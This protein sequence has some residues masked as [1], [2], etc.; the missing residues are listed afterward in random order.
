VLFYCGGG[1]CSPSDSASILSHGGFGK[2]TL[3]R[4]HQHQRLFPGAAL[5]NR[6]YQEAKNVKRGFIGWF[7]ALP[8]EDAAVCAMFGRAEAWLKDRGVDHIV[9][10]FNGAAILGVGVRSAAHDED[11]MSTLLR[12]FTRD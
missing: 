7:S 2:R 6:R 1:Q 10:P 12:R 11:P 3:S 5:I 8:R 4:K 9:A